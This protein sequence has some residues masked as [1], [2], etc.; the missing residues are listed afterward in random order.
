MRKKKSAFHCWKQYSATDSS[1]Y[2]LPAWEWGDVLW[3]EGNQCFC[4]WRITMDTLSSVQVVLW[5]LC[6]WKLKL[7][8]SGYN[9][10]IGWYN[11]VRHLKMRTETDTKS[12]GV[13]SFARIFFEVLTGKVPFKDIPL[14]NILQSICDRVRLGFIR[15]G[16]LS[17]Y[18]LFEKCWSTNAVKHPWFHVVCHLL[19]DYKAIV[20][21]HPYGLEHVPHD[22]PQ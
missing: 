20:L 15:C 10:T 2:E 3:F 9:H 4:Q 22:N 17:W 8:D 16:L 14:R 1:G 21:K 6:Q 11:P 7:H 13:Y 19:V 5:G 18:V 12:V